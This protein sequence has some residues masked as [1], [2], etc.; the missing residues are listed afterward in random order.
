MV[1]GNY[2]IKIILYYIILYEIDFI[3]GKYERFVKYIYENGVYYICQ[4]LNSLKPGKGILY[5]KNI[6]IKY[7]G[8]FVNVKIFR[9]IFI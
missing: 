7:E 8:D 4:W 1:N 2:I 9:R 6:S 3:N 5:Y